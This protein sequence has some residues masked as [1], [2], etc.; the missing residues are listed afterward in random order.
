MSSSVQS[1]WVVDQVEA[2]IV[3]LISRDLDIEAI[4]FPSELLPATLTE[5]DLLTL[6]ATIDPEASAAERDQVV[7]QLNALSSDDDGGDFS[8]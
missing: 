6:S 5:G 7:N 2:G 4:Y 8:L 3:T 1:V